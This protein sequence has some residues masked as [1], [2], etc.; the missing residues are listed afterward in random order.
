MRHLPI[1]RP[2]AALLA[3]CLMTTA[4][5]ASSQIPASQT[6][7]LAEG[8][9]APKGPQAVAP[10]ST[11]EALSAELVGKTFYLRG[12]YQDD[13]LEFAADG[14][15]V[16]SPQKGSF[17]LSGLEIDKVKYNKHSMEIEA[18]R[19]GLHFFGALP[20]END[21]TP[22]ERIKVDPK[23]AVTIEI[24]RLVIEPEKKKKKKDEKKGEKKD[25]KEIAANAEPGND[26]ARTAAIALLASAPDA[27]TMPAGTASALAGAPPA[28]APE[29]DPR[30]S[31]LQL[32]KALN[33][34]FA[35]ALNDSVIATLPEYW[36]NYFATKEGKSRAV[37][38]D[39]SALRPGGDVK[40]PHLLTVL[41]PASSDYAQKNNIAGMVFLQMVVDA[42]GRPGEVTIVRPI[43]FGLDE[44]AVDAVKRA[45]FRP[46]TLNGKPVTEVVNLQVTFRIYSDRT[47]PNGAP[48]RQ[49]PTQ[50]APKEAPKMPPSNAPVL[51]SA[52]P[53]APGV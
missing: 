53:A 36:Q 45:Q 40:P 31:I 50:V 10:A 3:A 38:L 29:H 41:D 23:K 24:D 26:A 46:G 27:A 13:K 11:P 20:Y 19:I 25:E 28:V 2:G 49:V 39:A 6:A 21:A 33:V 48:T 35:P 42:Q 51:A 37:R 32:S 52:E 14:K 34:M 18:H 17:A 8:A 16:G 15:A 1:A 7:A 5:F 47:R 44:L 4:P 12:F 9:K 43:G 30:V 22:F